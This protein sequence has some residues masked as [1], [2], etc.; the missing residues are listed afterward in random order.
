[1]VYIN[2]PYVPENNLIDKDFAKKEIEFLNINDIA[3]ETAYA[4]IYNLHPRGVNFESKDS[5]EAL[6]LEGVLKRLGV[7]YRESEESE[8]H[9]R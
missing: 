9:S 1:M 2:I 4:A 5:V 7:P 3:K 6:M 8:Y